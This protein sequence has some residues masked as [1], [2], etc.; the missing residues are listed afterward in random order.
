M[1]FK[2]WITYLLQRFLWYVETPRSERKE[3]KRSQKEPWSTRW[4]GLVPFS[5]KMALNRQ[6]RMR[7]RS[8]E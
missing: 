3:L 5:M 8:N 2:D 7:G 1:S 6:R 4:F